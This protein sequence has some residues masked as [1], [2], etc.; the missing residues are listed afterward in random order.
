MGVERIRETWYVIRTGA[1]QEE[2]A[3]NN[4]NA[5]HVETF[6]PKLK[7][8]RPNPFTGATNWVS[9][10]MFPRYAFARFDASR[11]LHQVSY[12]RGVHS[13]V[14]FGGVPAVVDDAII[15]LIQEQIGVDG[16]VRMGVELKVGDRVR[17]KDGPLSNFV[18]VFDYRIDHTSRVAILLTAVSYQ[19]RI[20]IESESIEKVNS[21]FWM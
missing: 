12:T 6:L 20:V 17:I 15:E 11:L 14:R 4:L 13:V 8:R 1:R 7:V 3:V 10:P 16:L 19:P 2:R 21:A 9:G 5:S 18:G